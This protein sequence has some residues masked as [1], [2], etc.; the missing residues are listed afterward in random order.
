MEKVR[1]FNEDEFGYFLT[2]E[3][4]QLRDV[5][6]VL[7]K[8]HLF[9]EFAINCYLESLSKA[10]KSN[11]FKE[12]F[13]YATKLKMLVHFGNFKKEDKLILESIKLLNKL[14]NGIAHSL[15]VN[16]QLIQE[17]F[18]S[19]DKVLPPNRGNFRNEKLDTPLRLTSAIAII[20]GMVFG[21]YLKIRDQIN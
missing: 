10:E 2:E 19:L 8:G 7:L 11:F 14:R 4:S 21:R 12:N 17:F 3:L 5:T 16:E 13:T 9:T 6:L 1:D 18:T 15:N 20:C